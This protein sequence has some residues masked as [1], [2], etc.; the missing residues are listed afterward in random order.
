MACYLPEYSAFLSYP[1]LICWELD[2]RV[3]RYACEK[4]WSFSG[5]VLSVV[6]VSW[7]CGLKRVASLLR[8]LEAAMV[9]LAVCRREPWVVLATFAGSRPLPN[10]LEFLILSSTSARSC[11]A[12]CLSTRWRRCSSYLFSRLLS[13]RS[14][15]AMKSWTD[16]DCYA[17]CLHFSRSLSTLTSNLGCGGPGD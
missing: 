9:L 5:S 10:T 1:T 13:S 3:L 15:S 16:F 17:P 12:L 4:L 14:I 6:S 7:A 8:D 2:I 11:R